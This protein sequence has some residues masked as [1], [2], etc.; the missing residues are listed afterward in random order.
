MTTGH[1]EGSETEVVGSHF[2][3]SM[4]MK[5][6]NVKPWVCLGVMPMTIIIEIANGH[7]DNW[8]VGRNSMLIIALHQ[9]RN[10]YLMYLLD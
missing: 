10:A 3:C 6:T 1:Q 5:P 8:F 4:L 9:H 2:V 7:S